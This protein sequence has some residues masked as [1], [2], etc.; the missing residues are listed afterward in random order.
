MAQTDFLI[1]VGFSVK[2]DSASAVRE[3]VQLAYGAHP[4]GTFQLAI[5]FSTLEFAHPKTLQTL[6]G[7]TG[8]IVCVG[9]SGGAILSPF[10]TLKHGIALMLLGLP[11]GVYYNTAAVSDIRKKTP[12]AAGEELGEKLLYGFKDLRR[13]F[14]V[15]FADGLMRDSS[16]FLYGLHKQLGLSFPLIGAGASDNLRFQKTYVYYKQDVLTDAA[17]GLVWGGKLRFGVGIQHGW[18]PLGKPRT[19]TRAAGNI[20]FAIDGASA[21][22]MYEE[23]FGLSVSQLRKEL[24]QLSVRYPLGIYLPEE[25]TYLLRTLL[26]IHEEG[27]LEFQGNVP[28]GSALRLM[29]GTKESCLQAT[30]TAVEEAARELPLS[31]AKCALVFD[32]LSRSV[33]LGRDIYRESALL[34]NHF[35]ALP[36]IGICTFAE[37]APLHSLNF[38]GRAYVHNQTITVLTIGG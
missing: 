4:Q 29:I 34:K 26:H 23:Y 21:V 16:F 31:Q 8:E 17:C 37:D 5:V 14:A 19:V 18:K 35:G 25:R 12:L 3:A 27:S 7:L 13:D 30:K 36:F 28:E 1:G 10:G 9:C 32:S 20:V 38:R 33:L 11:Q 15:F 2:K 6:C 24:A 22:R